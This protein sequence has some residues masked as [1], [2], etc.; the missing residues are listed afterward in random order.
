MKKI[1]TLT[2]LLALVSMFLLTSLPLSAVTIGDLLD[3]PA[4]GDDLSVSTF[5]V[6]KDGSFRMRSD[7]EIKQRLIKAGLK[8]TATSSSR[9]KSGSSKS[10]SKTASNKTVYKRNGI[11]VN[12]TPGKFEIVFADADAKK[13]FINGALNRGWTKD[14]TSGGITYYTGNTPTMLVDGNT[15][16]FK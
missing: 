8:E 9:S 4:E 2:S 15:I 6:Y 7:S 11:T 12:L 1:K 3:R 10:K 16:Y 13:A 5:L 14:R